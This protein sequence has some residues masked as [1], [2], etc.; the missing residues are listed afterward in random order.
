MGPPSYSITSSR[1]RPDRT[2]QNRQQCADG[3][4]R[5]GVSPPA[6]RGEGLLRYQHAKTYGVARQ[7][8]AGEGVEHTGGAPFGGISERAA[9]GTIVP[10]AGIRRSDGIG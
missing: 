2:S 6:A 8:A 7:G 4:G 5:N 3:F 9:A 10:I 1:F